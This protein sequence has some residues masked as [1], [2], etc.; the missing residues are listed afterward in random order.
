M[1][2]KTFDEVIQCINAKS[3]NTRQKGAM[4]EQIT[5]NYLLTNKLYDFIDTIWLWDSFPYRFAYDAKGQNI[6]ID[7]VAL[8][9][10]DQYIAIQ[11]KC[12]GENNTIG[13]NDVTNFV[14]CLAIAFEDE[15]HVT[16]HFT[17]AYWVQSAGHISSK[18]YEHFTRHNKQNEKTGTAIIKVISTVQNSPL[19]PRAVVTTVPTTV[20]MSM[21]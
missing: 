12:Y 15:D 2:P 3:V 5:K 13:L 17:Q 9:K 8:T 19:L 1:A 7:L 21:N 16:H 18:V 20:K 10:D 6:G 14:S 4:F 11:C